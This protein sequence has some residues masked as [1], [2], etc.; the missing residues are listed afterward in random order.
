LK[1]D[2]ASRKNGSCAKPSSRLSFATGTEQRPSDFWDEHDFGKFDDIQEVNEIQLY[3]FP[4]LFL[5][6]QVCLQALWA[7]AVGWVEH[8]ETQQNVI[9]RQYCSPHRST[10][11]MLLG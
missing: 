8:R 5:L 10:Q 4:S 3:R 11:S 9:F 1:T 7:Q 6:S 2:A